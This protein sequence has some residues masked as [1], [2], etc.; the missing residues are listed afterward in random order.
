MSLKA[1]CRI[2]VRHKTNPIVIMALDLVGIVKYL[3]FI[4][5]MN[6]I[7]KQT[8]PK[9]CNPELIQLVFDKII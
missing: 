2:A 5:L 3:I 4:L 9:R 6:P 1:I 8:K 7:I